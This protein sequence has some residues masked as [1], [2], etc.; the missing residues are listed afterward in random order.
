[1]DAKEIYDFLNIEKNMALFNEKTK[2]ILEI[3]K[4]REEK[5]NQGNKNKF[6]LFLYNI[7]LWKTKKFKIPFMNKWIKVSNI[8]DF[9][10]TI[11]FSILAGTMIFM[12]VGGL[13]YITQ[14]FNITLSL[15][16]TIICSV[17]IFVG[18]VFLYIGRSESKK[19]QNTDNLFGDPLKSNINFTQAE[20]NRGENFNKFI[21]YFTADKCDIYL[22]F[23]RIN[24]H[25]IKQLNIAQLSEMVG[26]LK[27]KNSLTFLSNHNQNLRILIYYIQSFYFTEEQNKLQYQ[28]IIF[29]HLVFLFRSDSLFENHFEVEDILLN[30]RKS[31]Q[32][33][34]KINDSIHNEETFHK[35]NIRKI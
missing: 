24:E 8:L 4:L 20:I 22:E 23:I 28:I 33:Y 16:P 31:T 35:R 21:N 1:M 14:I 30:Y 3:E 7:E 17:L 12:I 27:E 2:Q 13:N 18:I 15:F 6:R 9:F 11:F 29:L 19:I 5:I 32:L 34:D 26:V 25:N 10:Y